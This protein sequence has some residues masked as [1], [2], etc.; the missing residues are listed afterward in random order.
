VLPHVP[1]RQCVLSLPFRVRFPL[2]CDSKL[3]SAVRRILVRTILGRHRAMPLLGIESSGDP[4]FRALGL[5]RMRADELGRRWG[6]E[7][8]AVVV[9]VR[10]RHARTESEGRGARARAAEPASASSS[11]SPSPT[12]TSG[13]AD[14]NAAWRSHAQ[15]D[16]D[17][18]TLGVA[19]LLG[20]V[21][22]AAL[23]WL[24]HRSLFEARAQSFDA[25][26]YGRSLWAAA[27]GSAENTVLGVHWLT[28]HANLVLYLLAP[29]A[30]VADPVAILIVAQALSGGALVALFV[31]HAAHE[32]RPL[33]LIAVLLACALVWGSPL[34][35]NPFLFD[36]RP[37][38]IGVPL[39]TAGLLRMQ[40]R[41]CADRVSVGW[42]FASLLVREEYS[43]IVA[44]ALTLLPFERGAGLGARTRWILALS[45][46][47]YTVF[48][49]SVGRRWIGGDA[50]AARVADVTTSL[51]S[52]PTWASLRSKPEILLAAALS[53]GGLVALGWRWSVPAWPGLAFLLAI[54]K[55]P[56]LLFNAHY[57]MFVVPGLC[58]AA[59]AGV[60]RLRALSGARRRVAWIGVFA[61]SLSCGAFWSAAPGGGR[62]RAAY[63]D[64]E[65]AA[66]KGGRWDHLAQYGQARAL[67]RRIPAEA[68]C[69]LPYALSAGFLDRG[70]AWDNTRLRRQLAAREPLP[71]EL[72]WAA[73]LSNEWQDVG[74]LLVEEHG[75]RLVD[76]AHEWLALLTR[77][78]SAAEED[79]TIP[80]YTS[81]W[82]DE[83]GLVARWPSAGIC[84]SR[85]ERG[86][87]GRITL[88][89]ARQAEVSAELRDRP[90]RLILGGTSQ[91]IELTALGGLLNARQLALGRALRFESPP[92][93]A[94]PEVGAV[95][96]RLAVRY[97]DGTWRE[98]PAEHVEHVMLR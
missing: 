4:R 70:V 82:N 86:L 67:L 61:V 80:R 45:A 43:M 90:L 51:V 84:A 77:A 47:A 73:V 27:H 22:A 33:T 55:L 62:F 49:V 10:A 92:G 7:V 74:K 16:A 40:R 15:S 81:T 91:P 97:D 2:A 52:A 89:A 31:F 58:V 32:Q 98:V 28:I 75:F 6:V 13:T 54:Q 96:A 95:F 94:T 83:G 46:V 41:R 71:D 42:L 23:A 36:V 1:I 9:A 76:T 5:R 12:S 60:E 18:S 25:M 63:F 8:S 64:L 38:L 3:C 79:G 87:D 57:S 11:G 48:Y 50:A 30:R 34:A 14:G 21:V 35:L 88:L 78:E 56:E 44:P 72:R 17:R 68:A 39:C 66:E 59:L 85:F 93:A 65:P 26:I 19:L 24:L 37:D 69:A 20:A 29:C 53:C